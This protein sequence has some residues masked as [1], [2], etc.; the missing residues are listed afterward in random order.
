MPCGKFGD[1]VDEHDVRVVAPSQL[2]GARRADVPCA[3]DRHFLRRPRVLCGRPAVSRAGDDRVCDLARPDGGRVVAGRL[4]VVG[5]ARPLADHARRSR[6]PVGRRRRVSSRWR[7]ISIPESIIAI[8]LTLFWPVYFGAEP[9]VGSKTRRHRR[10]SRRARDRDR[11]SGRR[12]GRRRRRRR[13]SAGRGRRTPRAAARAASKGCRRSG[14][15]TLDVRVLVGDVAGD[16]KEQ[17]V[18]ELHDV[19]LVDRRDLA[20]AVGRA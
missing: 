16:V 6:A 11:R 5:H 17:A 19:G 20:A 9:W 14:R 8:G 10:S 2:L 4:H 3:D 7:S 12:R 18:R 1:D 13:G 15:R